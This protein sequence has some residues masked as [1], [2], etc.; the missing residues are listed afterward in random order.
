MLSLHKELQE[1]L[2]KYIEE[3]NTSSNR[4]AKSIPVS[5]TTLSLWFNDTYKGSVENIDD[6]VKNFLDRQEEIA[7]SP[8]QS[9]PFIQTTSAERFFETAKICH[10]DCEI[11]V[12]YGEA[13]CGKTK[14]AKEYAKNNND[15]ILIEADLGYSVKIFFRELHRQLGLDGLGGIHDLFEGC[16]ARLKDTG[17]F[18]IIDEAENLPYR[19]LDL[20]RR[21]Y[22]KANIGILLV[23]LPRLLYN[24]RGKKG[25]YA[26]LFSRVGIASRLERFSEEDTQNLVKTFI[27]GTN[28]VW[29]VFHQKSGGNGRMLEKLLL[30]AKRTAHLNNMAVDADV[31][32]EVS[33]LLIK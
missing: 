31:V 19:A 30:R 24:L 13:G 7:K 4:V 28:G 17:R 12:V 27:P 15:V 29:K 18:I 1:Q 5:A 11:G 6:K 22:D 21:L 9:I 2:A 14:S 10:F 32:N 8:R 26:Q 20:I 25:E 23:G 16:V 3:K 33:N